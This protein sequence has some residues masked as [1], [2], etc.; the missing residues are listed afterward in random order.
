MWATAISICLKEGER[1]WD[2]I[3]YLPRAPTQMKSCCKV[4]NDKFNTE[5]ICFI[6]WLN[7]DSKHQV[8]SIMV[9]SG[10]KCSSTSTGYKSANTSILLHITRTKISILWV[11]KPY[12][13]RQPL[14][15]RL[16]LCWELC[17]T[18]VKKGA[19][20]ILPWSE[21]ISQY[22]LTL[23]KQNWVPCQ[24]HIS[25][26]S[27]LSTLTWGQRK[28]TPHDDNMHPGTWKMPHQFR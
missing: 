17:S 27:S 1:V 11:L 2:F 6:L 18:G 15:A 25:I 13:P 12:E 4:E 3:S 5:C 14:M 23:G 26:H 22:L 19:R 8:V 20:S 24:Q 28:L 7:Q 21:Q 10:K 9:C 16:K